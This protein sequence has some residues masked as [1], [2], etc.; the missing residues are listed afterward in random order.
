MMG[1]RFQSRVGNVREVVGLKE[2]KVAG[3]SGVCKMGRL[4]KN[5]GN[6]VNEGVWNG[7]MYRGLMRLVEMG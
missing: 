4:E 3:A 6:I 5:G 1:R 7:R 2:G